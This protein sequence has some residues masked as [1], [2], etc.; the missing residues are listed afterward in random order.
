MKPGVLPTN[1]PR[2]VDVRMGAIEH[3]I[4]GRPR[5]LGG[6]V[7]RRL[8]PSGERRLVGP[9]I[10]FDQMGPAR[11]TPGEGLDVRPHPHIALATVTYLF[12]G[13]ILHRDNLGSEQPIRPGAV[14][15]MVA[16]SGVAH[17][18]RTASE[19]RKAGGPVFGIQ[20]W[21][22]LPTR[23]EERQ[24]SFDHHPAD[25]IPLVERDGVQLRVVMGSVFG[26]TSP[27]RV[28]SPTFYV[29][30]ILERGRSL[31]L[32]AVHT[33]RAFHVVDGAVELEGKVFR[34]GSMV[35]LTPGAEPELKALENSRVMLLGGEPLDGQRYIWW[36]FVSSSRERIEQAKRDWRERRFAPIPGDNQEF[37]PLPQE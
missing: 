31:T 1:E 6:F 36:N 4:D 29:D 11:F 35:V 13:E 20:S 17:S 32:E 22:A 37:I 8:L 15:F 10:F 19:R 9:F 23:E 14:N 24:A 7:V 26:A 5:D 25:S 3:V 28:L 27:V 21:L 18:E 2:D 33:E 12:E 34:Q 30:A 16:G